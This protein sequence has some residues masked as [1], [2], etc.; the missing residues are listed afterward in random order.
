MNDGKVKVVV[1]LTATDPYG[2]ATVTLRRIEHSFPATR[3]KD[4]EATY[5]FAINS[6][7][8]LEGFSE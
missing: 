5:E 8:A 4:A 7:R 1:A 6:L 3:I 2:A